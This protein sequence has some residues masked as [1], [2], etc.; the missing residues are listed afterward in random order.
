M[1]RFLRENWIFIVAPLVLVLLGLV[2]L[3]AFGE[4]SP[5]SFIY[6]IF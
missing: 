2:A 5:S 6:N 3:I 1:A 4:D